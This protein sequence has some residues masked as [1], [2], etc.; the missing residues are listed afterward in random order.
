MAA[1][2]PRS[3]QFPISGMHCQGCAT[4]V[5]RLLE[6]VAGVQSAEVSYGAGRALLTLDGE[7]VEQHLRSALARGGYGLPEGALG[8]RS[9]AQDVAFRRKEEA[10][11]RR[12]EGRGALG[13]AV[14]LAAVLSLHFTHAAP[15]VAPLVAA[16]VLFICGRP[17][18]IR[19]ARALRRGV[20][21]M[22]SLVGMGAFSAWS[23][24]AL[25]AFFP[26]LF[27]A[28]AHHVHAAVMILAFVL[29]GRWLEGRA[30]ARAGEA[31][32][33]L[34]DLAPPTARVL[35]GAEQVELPLDEVR[36]DQR[37]LVRPGERVPVD[38]KVIEG[39]SSLDESM[40]T[41]E[42][43][44][45]PRGPGERVHAGTL[46]GEGALTLRATGVG[47]DTALGRIAEAVHQAQATRAPIQAVADR[48]SAVFVP[49]VL[50]LGT[51]TFFAWLLA[52]GLPAAIAHTVA[53]LVIACPCALGLATPTAIVVAGGR[54]AREGLLV[55]DAAAIE[56]LAIIDR[57]VFDKTGTLTAGE[58]SLEH[59][60]ALT[61]VDVDLCL[62]RVAAVEKLSEQ[63]LARALVGAARKRGL[64]L[65]R[66]RAFA[67]EPGRGVRA[68]VE[69]HALWI[70]SPSAAI[71]R[72]H[73]RGLVE[74]SIATRT[75]LGQTPVVVEED[76]A[77]VLV[78]GL[79]DRARPEAPSALQ[80]LR[81]LG[82]E[83]EILSGDHPAAVRALAD[84]LGISQAAGRLSPEDKA[85][86]LGA[87]IDA[88]ER[89]AMVGDGINDA[90]A[91]ARATVGVAMGGGAD[92]A[93]ESADAALLRDDLG[94]LPALVRLARR[95][96]VII[97]QNLVWAFAYNLLALPVAAG[98]FEGAGVALAPTWAAGAMALS[99]LSVVS[100]SLRLKRVRIEPRDRE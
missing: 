18:L 34:L 46:N 19:G 58:P 8:E 75:D 91:L 10:A 86:Q 14:G 66:A 20:P 36:V 88:G 55:K 74:S 63:P 49:V 77:L 27:G 85:A 24:G 48:V 32:R 71:S 65:P 29:F 76:G 28:A 13:A 9:A 82:L 89:V 17:I 93:L 21:D 87:R 40:L 1:M 97:R 100:N 64:R 37:V 42:P 33:A 70:G 90:P 98:L 23:A 81:D 80:A 72:G 12:E 83:L 92:V 56:H 47:A 44:P 53:V 54:G 96:R 39:E 67:A 11:R 25:G 43:F 84:Q 59:V 52:G 31:V 50:T 5:A 30:R 51:I 95:T 79:V 6:G 41:G 7:P 73:E 62:A 26:T 4:S 15:W 61:E 2:S 16:P 35:R 22:D 60:E 69:G 94:R 78:L 99:S 45:V 57:M 38:G 3:A 68:E